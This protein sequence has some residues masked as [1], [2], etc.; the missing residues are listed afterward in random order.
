MSKAHSWLNNLPNANPPTEEGGLGTGV[1]GDG[2]LEGLIE[3]QV[4]A[5]KAGAPWP[6]QE[7][8]EELAGHQTQ[9]KPPRRW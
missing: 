4:G 8:G 7:K 1:G 5:E 9:G 3:G 6:G 2:A